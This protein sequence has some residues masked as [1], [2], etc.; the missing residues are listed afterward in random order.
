MY[1]DLRV[2]THLDS[3]NQQVGLAVTVYTVQ[4]AQSSNS[5]IFI[6]YLEACVA[7]LSRYSEIVG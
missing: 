6:G 2:Y 3:D 5:D 4:E 7:F 1:S